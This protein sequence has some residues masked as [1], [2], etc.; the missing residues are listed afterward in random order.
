M[1]APAACCGEISILLQNRFF[2]SEATYPL[3]K[4][5]WIPGRSQ[6]DSNGQ[7]LYD[8]CELMI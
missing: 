6:L 8:A 5:M 4:K 3:H 1:S 2:L 7:S